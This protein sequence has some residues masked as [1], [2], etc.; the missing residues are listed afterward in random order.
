MSPTPRP[1][2]RS[3]S[4]R[5][6]PGPSTPG[7]EPGREAR[8]PGSRPGEGDASRARPGG[9]AAGRSAVPGR[10]AT[11]ASRR[12]VRRNETERNQGGV[13]SF[14][15]FRNA[16]RSGAS[17]ERAESR[18]RRSA[19]SRQGGGQVVPLRADA[20]TSNPFA[21][22]GG[23]PFESATGSAIAEPASG[24]R[25]RTLALFGTDGELISLSNERQELLCSV[26]GLMVKLG[27][28]AVAG[29]SLLRLAGTYQQR[30]ERQGEIS[31]VLELQNARMAKA[32]ERFDE[33]FMVEGEQRLIREQSQW[34]APD[35]L[36][37]VWQ[38][39]G[40]AFPTVETAAAGSGKGSARP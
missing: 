29:V 6:Q 40:K 3:R 13:L 25:F 16:D 17:R 19:A 34:I 20:T 11:P 12:S 24:S 22:A 14:L 1:A 5:R 10:P 35:R 9:P 18:T 15:P 2:P 38:T 26:I 33:L 21:S 8:A 30:M 32:R 28:I 39:K 31:A 7:R 23:D 36:R 27:L 37:I 4:A